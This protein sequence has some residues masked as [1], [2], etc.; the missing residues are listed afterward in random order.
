MEGAVKQHRM[1]SAAAK[2]K[3]YKFFKTPEKSDLAVS[4]LPDGFLSVKASDLD[5]DERVI[6]LCVVYPD[7]T[8]QITYG[9]MFEMLK[10]YRNLITPQNLKKIGV[11]VGECARQYVFLLGNLEKQ[12]TSWKKYNVGLLKISKKHQSMPAL[13]G[14]ED[15][16]ETQNG[17]VDRDFIK[18]SDISWEQDLSCL[19]DVV[20]DYYAENIRRTVKKQEKEELTLDELLVS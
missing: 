12:L 13:K 1:L 17:V 8:T 7:T 9:E 15:I 18:L 16:I 14:L 4:K 3:S 11:F 2:K 20:E 10:N 5:T 6:A 19:S